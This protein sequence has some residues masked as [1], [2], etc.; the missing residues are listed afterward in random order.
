MKS[1]S[2]VAAG[3]ILEAWTT[4]R[5]IASRENYPSWVTSI[6]DVYAVHEALV[7]HPLSS[8]LGGLVG[9]K[10]GS[11]GMVEGQPCVYGPLFAACMVESPAG[12]SGSAANL[13]AYEA[14]FAFVV[15]ADLAPRDS[16]RSE[17][18]VWQAIA[19]VRL[20]I[21]LV[22]K[23][24]TLDDAT[25]FEKLADACCAAGVVLG[26]RLLP[27][28]S[29]ASAAAAGAPSVTPAQLAEATAT[30]TAGG[31]LVNTGRG[32]N[33]PLGSPLV[34]LTWCA[35]HLN[36]RGVTLCAGQ[37]VIGG[38][39]AKHSFSPVAG[40]LDIVADFGPLGQVSTVLAP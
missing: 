23:R 27:A 10:Q 5:P 33:C 15:G 20:A 38:A 29:A 8:Q 9:Y 12:L 17:E 40:A 35:N 30:L 22:G 4:G 7:A 16:P 21:E 13:F 25:N 36:S 39:I 18:E 37:V 19:E 14:E 31:E 34:A 26:P 1:R 3:V 11:I 6:E 24:H 2:V 28:G 32:S